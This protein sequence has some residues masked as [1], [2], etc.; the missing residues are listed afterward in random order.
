M[1]SGDTGL[2]GGEW[3]EEDPVVVVCAPVCREG[4][5]EPVRVCTCTC[6]VGSS[7]PEGTHQTANKTPRQVDRP[8][9]KSKRHTKKKKKY[10]GNAI[11]IYIFNDLF[12]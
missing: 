8:W 7:M 6:S 3:Q 2:W 5:Q 12:I 10:D 4:L 1:P 9:E 11:Y